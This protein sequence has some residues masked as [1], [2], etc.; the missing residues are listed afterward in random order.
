MYTRALNVLLHSDFIYKRTTIGK[1]EKKLS[2]YIRN[3]NKNV[4]APLQLKASILIFL[5]F[6]GDLF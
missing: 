3:F 6:L 1:E 2:D 5:D 4:A